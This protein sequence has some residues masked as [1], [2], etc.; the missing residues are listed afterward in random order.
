MGNLIAQLTSAIIPS[1]SSSE[2]S[3]SI[4]LRMSLNLATVINPSPTSSKILAQEDYS[5]PSWRP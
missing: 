5:K 2:M 1:S 4:S 3:S